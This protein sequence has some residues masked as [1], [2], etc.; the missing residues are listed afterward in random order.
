VRLAHVVKLAAAV[1]IAKWAA[2]ELAAASARWRARGP[3]PVDS[4][5]APGRMPPPRKLS[6]P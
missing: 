3:A 1:W 2:E 4:E 5:R 6:N